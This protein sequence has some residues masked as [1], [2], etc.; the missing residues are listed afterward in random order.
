M[1]LRYRVPTVSLSPRSLS[2]PPASRTVQS[3]PSPSIPLHPVPFAHP[4]LHHR[5]STTLTSHLLLPLSFPHFPYY[6]LLAIFSSVL[7]SLC[8]RSASS[9]SFSPL[10]LAS[11]ISTSLDSRTSP[12]LGRFRLIVSPPHLR[13]CL[14]IHRDDSIRLPCKP[15]ALG[16]DSIRNNFQPNL[17]PVYPREIEASLSCCLPL[18]SPD[19]DL[20]LSTYLPIRLEPDTLFLS[21]FDRTFVLLVFIEHGPQ[22]LQSDLGHQSLDV[23]AKQVTDNIFTH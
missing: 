21:H 7:L 4:P 2:L 14:D 10:E 6:H 12:T 16:C 11:F 9:K 23:Q 8:T 19:L 13:L 5:H 17:C 1:L 15:N 18:L 3:S 20:R 22:R